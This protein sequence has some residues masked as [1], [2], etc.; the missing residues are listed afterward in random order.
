MSCP[1]KFAQ[2]PI[3]NRV[4]RAK[5]CLNTFIWEQ[6]S[7]QPGAKRRE[8][9]RICHYLSW[10]DSIKPSVLFSSFGCCISKRSFYRLFWQFKSSCNIENKAKVIKYYQAPFPFCVWSRMWNVLYRFL[11]IAFSSASPSLVSISHCLNELA[12]SYTFLVNIWHL[13]SS[14]DLENKVRPSKASHFFLLV[15]MQM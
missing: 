3:I 8:G 4:D 13:W 7:A 15:T 6:S 9:C 10:T 11:I 5:F 1:C 14:S 12:C 2:S